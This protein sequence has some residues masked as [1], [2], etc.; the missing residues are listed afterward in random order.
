MFLDQPNSLQGRLPAAHPQSTNPQ[1]GGTEKRSTTVNVAW[2]NENAKLERQARQT[3]TQVQILEQEHADTVTTLKQQHVQEIGIIKQNH[4]KAIEDLKKDH[5]K[6]IYSLETIFMHNFR[7]QEGDNDSKASAEYFSVQQEKANTSTSVTKDWLEDGKQISAANMTSKDATPSVSVD[8]KIDRLEKSIADICHHMCGLKRDIIKGNST[9]EDLSSRIDKINHEIYN[10]KIH[11]SLDKG[12][13]A[14]MELT[15]R[16]L[17][18]GGT[19]ERTNTE[20]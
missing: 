9:G 18:E 17:Y 1:A 2:K 16:A 4:A 12:Q 19:L 6:T 7:V 14:K 3:K 15:A 10:I 13:L 5:A 20:A 8:D 11:D